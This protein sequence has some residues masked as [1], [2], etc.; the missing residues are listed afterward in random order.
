MSATT[1]LAWRYLFRRR[2]RAALTTTAIVFGV[3]LVV[4]MGSMIPALTASLTAGVRASIEHVDL[5]LSSSARA[6][7]G[8]ELT[9]KV[10]GVP[11]VAKASHRLTVF[12]PFAAGQAPTLGGQP[13]SAVQVVGVA[14][15]DADPVRPLAVLSG[16]A[17]QGPSELLVGEAL[18]ESAWKVG[19]TVELPAASGRMRFTVVGTVASRPGGLESVYA[20]LADT[21]A[22]QGQS[23]VVSQ[24]DLLF[25]EGADAKQTQA[26][27]LDAAGPG[28]VA[29]SARSHGQLLDQ[30]TRMAVPMQAFGAL[31]MVMAGFIIFITFRTVVAERRRDL[32]LLRALGATRSAVVAMVTVEGLTLGLIGTALGIVVGL[33][34]ERLVITGMAPVWKSQVGLTLSPQPLAWST[35]AVSLALGVGGS[36]LSCLAPALQAGRVSPREAMRTSA[37]PLVLGTSRAR[38]GLGATVGVA[39]LGGLISGSLGAQATGLALFCLGV[40]LLGPLLVA[41]LTDLFSRPLAV[42]LAQETRLAQGNVQ[43]QRNRSAITAAVVAVALSIVVALAALTRSTIDGV[44]GQIDR[45]LR[46][47]FLVMPPTLMPGAGLGAKPEL[48]GRLARVEGVRSVAT[49]RSGLA[50]TDGVDLTLVGI[51][52]LAFPDVAALDFEAGG[53]DALAKLARGDRT[54]IVNGAWATS[55]SV[56]VGDRLTLQTNHGA[57]PFEVV[58]IGSEALFYRLPAAYLSQ[59]VLERDFGLG[60]DALLFVS[61]QPGAADDVVRARLASELEAWPGFVLRA[62]GEWKARMMADGQ[63]KLNSMYVLLVLLVLPA[64]IALANT[65][66]INVLERI[67]EIGL[68]RAIG[69]TRRQVR[70]LILAESLLLACAGGFLGIAGGLWMGLVWVRAMAFAGMKVAYVIPLGGAATAAV[71][72]VLF[73]G[74]AALVPARHAVGLKIVGALRH[75]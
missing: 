53:D 35:L 72:A 58:G 2:L 49:V 10:R 51:D 22:L 48:A 42:V 16:R 64:L 1:T 39:A 75:E 31:A 28:M 25:A 62:T 24:I 59:P 21:Q 14:L 34:L 15:D 71:L 8:E 52:P 57:E 37:G 13:L 7:F 65:L 4:V 41:T 6:P 47:D 68:L 33:G 36:V 18:A 74:L 55:H 63:K 66:G 73:G 70:R 5:S 60:L 23:G 9:A 56:H 20:P 38:L 11:G 50:R 40:I 30:L 45:T 29:E 46:S 12:V 19:S 3:A 44:M 17:L 61:K 32:G 69:T 43:R 27:V 26:A 54:M 67:R